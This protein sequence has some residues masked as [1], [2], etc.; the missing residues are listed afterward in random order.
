MNKDKHKDDSVDFWANKILNEVAEQFASPTA[1]LGKCSDPDVLFV[2][3]ANGTDYD[4]TVD[5]KTGHKGKLP[6]LGSWVKKKL[7]DGSTAHP[8]TLNEIWRL[9]K[10]SGASDEGSLASL[11]IIARESAFIG[12]NRNPTSS[13]KGLFQGLDGARPQAVA[14]ND[15]DAHVPMAKVF[16][17]E[18]KLNKT[19][20]SL[21]MFY[22]T[23]F[24]PAINNMSRQVDLM[25]M[26]GWFR[27]LASR[28]TYDAQ[29]LA[30]LDAD[31]EFTFNDF[32]LAPL[33]AFEE[34]RRLLK[35]RK[36]NPLVL[37]IHIPSEWTVVGWK[38]AK[39]RTYAMS[40]SLVPTGATTSLSFKHRH[41]S[42][43]IAL[44]EDPKA[45]VRGTTA[46]FAPRMAPGLSDDGDA[47][48]DATLDDSILT[49]RRAAPNPL[50]QS[51][52]PR[53]TGTITDT[54]KG[55]GVTV[56]VNFE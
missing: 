4:L 46:A 42:S 31:P 1:V 40:V 10:K 48:A 29:Y 17:K 34:F 21:K 30:R 39:D 28:S 37:T 7:P 20:V 13:A 18:A 5:W 8:F 23:V 50:R 49:P 41:G 22:I 33:S 43:T 27:H 24:Q 45:D 12:R 6:A 11:V 9:M 26:R 54:V 36:T 56:K 55:F 19:L 44:I 32:I 3:S 25:R 38:I 35:D 47:I 53:V 2:R 14:S 16:V 51:H 52:S 15:L